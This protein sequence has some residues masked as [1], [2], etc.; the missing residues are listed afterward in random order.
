[1]LLRISQ[2]SQKTPVLE[3][4]FNKV[5]GLQA[6]E[7]IFTESASSYDKKSK[8]SPLNN[9]ETNKNPRKRNIIRFNKIQRP[10]PFSQN[11]S[12]NISKFFLK[13]V[14]KNF[15]RKYKLRRIFKR[16]ILKRRYNKYQSDQ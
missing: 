3:F 8:Y 13:I 14:N 1:M 11:I 5:S 10:S 16:N 7:T 9:D 2:I 12:A 4:V 6:N 15:P